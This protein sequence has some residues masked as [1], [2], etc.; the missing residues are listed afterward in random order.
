[1][2]TQQLLVIDIGTSSVRAAV[3]GPDGS[4]AHEQVRQTLPDTPAPGLVEFDATALAD[5]ALDAARAT[6]AA[7]GP[8][9][10]VGVANQRASTVVWDADSG[11]PVAPAIGWQDLR[12]VGDCLVLQADGLRLA[13]NQSATKLSHLLELHD[14][15]RSR[16]LRF[17]TIDT[18]IIW[19]LTDG[20]AHVTDH[21]NAGITGLVQTGQAAWDPTV[22]DRL[23]IPASM[24]PTIVDSSGSIAEATALDGAP[25]ICGMAGD[26]QAS[27]IGQGAVHPG[28]AKITF[29]T[30]AMLDVCLGVERPPFDVRGP[31]GTFPIVAWQVADQPVWGL[32]AIML[33]A[34]TNVE[35]L[36]DDL[37]II[38][39]AAQSHE[40]AAACDDTDGVMYVPALLGLGTPRWD[41]GARGTLLGVTRGTGRPQIVR[42]VLE[43]VAQR[44]ADLVEATEA[45]A[46]INIPSLRVD[47]GMSEN[48]TFCQAVAD[49]TQRPVEVS[50]VT[51]ATTLGAAY[52]AGLATGVWSGFDEIAELWSPATVI[53]PGPA[54][55]RDRWRDA[56]DRA[57]TWHGDLT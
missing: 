39:T 21:T 19:Q 22:L 1:M 36:R 34:G 20:R 6:L 53:E 48:P 8:V 47:G 50:P 9:A 52:L 2:A 42:A 51:E 13:P 29:G 14:T 31:N 17:G 35:W 27:L 32:E 46:D 33:A 41:Y 24:L 3:V 23:S 16:N 38:E 30:G 11:Q 12:T 49:A 45:D 5:A 43:G 57:A 40:V 55:D 25:P 28:L 15:E 54:T 7:S 10:G 37:G 44:G 26:Q 4:V 56:V 18:W